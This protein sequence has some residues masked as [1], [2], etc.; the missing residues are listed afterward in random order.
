M[1]EYTFKSFIYVTLQMKNLN[2]LHCTVLH[3][4]H[5]TCFQK[6]KQVIDQSFY[7]SFSSYGKRKILPSVKTVKSWGFKCLEDK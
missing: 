6:Y 7:I 4:A 5:N 1:Q 3:V 2:T